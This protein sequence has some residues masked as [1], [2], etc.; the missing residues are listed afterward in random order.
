MAVSVSSAATPTYTTCTA[1]RKPT[2]VLA[3]PSTEIAPRIARARQ[4]ISDQ[5]KRERGDRSIDSL[6]S[7][8]P[9]DLHG[10]AR[11]SICYMEIGLY[12]GRISILL[13]PAFGYRRCCVTVLCALSRLL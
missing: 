3:L 7:R 2:I 12:D 10:T 13:G 8:P 1:S 6:I 9:P 5:L 4:V 11:N